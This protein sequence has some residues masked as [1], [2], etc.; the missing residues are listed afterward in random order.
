MINRF[1]VACSFVS[2]MQACDASVIFQLSAPGVQQSSFQG[3]GAY[4]T[5]TFNSLANLAATGTLAVGDYTSSG[6]MTVLA[7]SKFG[8]AGGTGKYAFTDSN[9]ELSVELGT[10][11]KYIGLWFT[12]SNPGN[13]VDV[14][15][16]GNLLATFDTQSLSDIV[17]LKASPNSVLASDGNYYSGDLWYGNPNAGL[18]DSDVGRFVYAYVNMG[19]SDPDATFDRIVMRGAY[20]EFDNLTTSAASFVSVVPEPAGCATLAGTLLL[21]F[22]MSRRRSNGWAAAFKG[23]AR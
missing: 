2:L 10:P 13:Y 12:C 21:G 1:L 14:Y 7:A 23:L 4:L 22:S 5:E 11:S 6:P 20:F 18:N 16:G 8:G 9:G 19:L 3:D 17:G 15:S